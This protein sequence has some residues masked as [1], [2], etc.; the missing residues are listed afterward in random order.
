MPEHAWIP[1]VILVGERWRWWAC[2]R[3]ASLTVDSQGGGRWPSHRMSVF[4]RRRTREGGW[5]QEVRRVRQ[6]R[7]AQDEGGKQGPEANRIGDGL[8]GGR[9]EAEAGWGWRDGDERGTRVERVGWCRGRCGVDGT[10]GRRLGGS[11]GRNGCGGGE[12][13]AEVGQR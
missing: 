10:G 1:K 4:W 7:E 9:S 12:A 11:G 5:W 8:R 13:E 2:L 3:Q 6:D